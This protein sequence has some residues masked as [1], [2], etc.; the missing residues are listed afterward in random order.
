VDCLKEVKVLSPTGILGYG[1][2]EESFLIGLAKNPDWIA[3]DAGSTDPGPYYLGSGK[4]FTTENAVKRDLTLLMRAACERDIPLVIGS[5]GGSGALSHLERD[6][7]IV[8]EIAN[9]FGLSFS[10]ATISAELEREFVVSE[11]K[12]GKISSLLPAPEIVEADIRNSAHI[13][14]Q[15]GVEPIIDALDGGAQIVLCGRCYDPAVFAAPA[16]RLGYSKALAI[17]LGKILECGC[18][19]SVPGSGSDCIMGYLR[20]DSFS[21]EPLNPLRRCTVTSVAAHTLYEKSNPCFLPGPGGAL[22]LSETSFCQESERRVKVAGSS[23]VDSGKKTVK[24][25]GTRFAGYRTISIAGN[26]DRIFISQVESILEDVK[27]QVAE[28]FRRSL[29]PYTLDFIVYGKNGVMGDLERCQHTEGHEICIVIDAVAS[30]QEEANTICSVA[31]SI[32]LHAGYPGRVATAGNL[33]FPY[34]PS[35]VAMG[36]VYVFSIYHLLEVD[37][38]SELFP[39]TYYN[40]VGGQVR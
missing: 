39:V 8:F 29:F 33:A 10:F 31:R 12:N 19:A 34:S 14:G 35:D 27:R 25:E 6:K 24:L 3:V 18:I 9:E 23:F 5:A 17:H 26:R 1:F 11:F 32:L 7:K 13:V 30:K 4:S 21:V 15:M 36:E 2:P 38:T 22:N 40:I 16:I 20:D 28:N 37:E